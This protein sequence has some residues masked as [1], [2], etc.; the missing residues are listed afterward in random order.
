MNNLVYH[1]NST[2]NIKFLNELVSIVTTNGFDGIDIDYPYKFPC[3]PSGFG[4]VF[5]SFLRS[6]KLQLSDKKLT[7]TAG[8]YPV[9]LTRDFTDYSTGIA[10]ADIT[11]DSKDL[12]LTNFISGIPPNKTGGNGT[13]GTSSSTSPPNT[14]AIV[15]GVIGSIIFVGALV[16]VGIILYRRRH[17][18]KMPNQLI[19]TNN[20]ACSDTNPQ[21]YS[22]IN[23]QVRPDINNRIY[24]DT[25]HKAF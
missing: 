7:I 16:T 6:I 2:Q 18:T 12:Q 20:Q 10:I 15:G 8:Q 25:N 4:D 24:S 5:L 9:N 17:R 22:D 1:P 13:T 11:K 21:V 19:N 3:D 23:R 14:S